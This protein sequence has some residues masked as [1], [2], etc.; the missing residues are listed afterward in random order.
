MEKTFDHLFLHDVPR[1]CPRHFN[2]RGF[3]LDLDDIKQLRAAL[4]QRHNRRRVRDSNP[5]WARITV[6]S[7]T[8]EHLT[9]HR[10]PGTPFLA[11]KECRSLSS[12][13]RSRA[14]PGPPLSLASTH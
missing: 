12:S 9:S 3:W 5:K 11:E 8:L 6:T 4:E 13:D 10:R 7:R 14:Y 1:H 2:P